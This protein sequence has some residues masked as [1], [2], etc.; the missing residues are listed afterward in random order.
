M[1]DRVSKVI[2]VETLSSLQMEL[3]KSQSRAIKLSRDKEI[4]HQID[5]KNETIESILNR[6][7]LIKKLM[8]EFGIFGLSTVNTIY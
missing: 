1:P 2:T 7:I 5:I 8:E 3:K 4:Q 6:G